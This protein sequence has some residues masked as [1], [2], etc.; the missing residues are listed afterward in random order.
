MSN[1]L[2][3]KGA[4]LMIGFVAC[5]GTSIPTLYDIGSNI[6]LITFRIA[7]KLRLKRFPVHLTVTKIENHTDELEY[8]L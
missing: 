7:K 8:C 1:H 3:K 6:S 4:F 2:S 5:G